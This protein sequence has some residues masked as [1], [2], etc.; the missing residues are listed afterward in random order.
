MTWPNTA[1]HRF[2]TVGNFSARAGAARRSGRSGFLTNVVL[3]PTPVPAAAELLLAAPKSLDV[4]SLAPGIKWNAS[5]NLLVAGNV[6]IAVANKGL[7]ANATA[8][9]GF[10]WTF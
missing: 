10:Q 2:L 1:A 5:G 7:R 9:F 8:V 4:V 6:L 3:V